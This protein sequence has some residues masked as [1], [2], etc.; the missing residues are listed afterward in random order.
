MCNFAYRDFMALSDPDV[1][2]KRPG[3]MRAGCH[4]QSSSSGVT[5][6][7]RAGEGNSIQSSHDWAVQLSDQAAFDFNYRQRLIGTAI[8]HLGLKWDVVNVND[9]QSQCISVAGR[10]ANSTEADV[11]G[12]LVMGLQDWQPMQAMS[13]YV[14]LLPTS[15]GHRRCWSPT[16]AW[17]RPGKQCWPLARWHKPWLARMPRPVSSVL[18]LPLHV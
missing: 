16:S 17:K 11:R 1:T 5:C 18:N 10:H 12:P 15:N 14:R 6:L 13:G 7:G 3:K 4:A 8:R 2:W 9:V